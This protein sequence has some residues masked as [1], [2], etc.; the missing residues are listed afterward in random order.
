MKSS[1]G[2]V[3]K[4]NIERNI[5][6]KSIEIFVDKTKNKNWNFGVKEL[7]LEYKSEIDSN[8]KDAIQSRKDA[9]QARKDAVQAKA[10][11]DSGKKKFKL[12]G[13]FKFSGGDGIPIGAINVPK[14]SVVVTAGGRKLVGGVDYTVNYQAGR[15]QILD[16]ALSASNTPIQVSVENKSTFGN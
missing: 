6:I 14:G 11:Q 10:L 3:Q 15:V 2:R 1:D 12:K 16:P 8:R 9:I 4:L 5:P 7:D 13:E